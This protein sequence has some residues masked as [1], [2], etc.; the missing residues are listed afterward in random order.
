MKCVWWSV[1]T[2]ITDAILKQIRNYI[3]EGQLTGC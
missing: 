1:V 3:G 2:L